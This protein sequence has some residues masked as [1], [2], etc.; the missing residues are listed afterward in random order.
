MVLISLILIYS[1]NNNKDY[2]VKNSKKKKITW[3]K[4]PDQFLIFENFIIWK[5]I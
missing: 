4:N 1:K 2:L 3:L 5:N